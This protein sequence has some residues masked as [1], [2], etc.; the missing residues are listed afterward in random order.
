MSMVGSSEDG[1]SESR[2]L[3]V[4]L[5]VSAVLAGG[6]CR[7]R[8]LP[9]QD[10]IG[11][12]IGEVMASVDESTK[13]SGATARLPIL[14]MPDEMKGPLW[15]Q[16]F[17]GVVHTAYAS[18]CVQSNFGACTAGARTRTF[19]SCAIGPAMLDGMVTL[20][21]SDTNSCAVTVVGDSVN[22]SASFTLTG[23]YGGTLAV[24]APGGGQTLTKTAVGFDY[25]VPGMER[26]LTGPGG[27][28]LFDI[29]T[30]TTMPIHI[31]GTSRADW[32]SFQAR[33]RS[34]TTWPATR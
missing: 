34:A 6:A 7:K 9:D 20:T 33:S 11:A 15:R 13:G 10:Q 19:D 28:T 5:A 25:S 1:A 8:T 4:V 31:T 32:S 14:R 3:T 17:D 2:N 27:H 30:R 23:P 24:S 26:V 12:L 22:R 18:S 21:Y 29:S 16:I